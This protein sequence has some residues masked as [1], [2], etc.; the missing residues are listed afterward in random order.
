MLQ[1]FLPSSRRDFNSLSE[2]EIL[3]LAISSEED[4][5]A[6][7]C[8]SRRGASF[9]AWRSRGSPS[10]HPAAMTLGI[11]LAS[12]AFSPPAG[13]KLAQP[14]KGLA[15]LALPVLAAGVLAVGA[16]TAA[17]A[18]SFL[19]VSVDRAWAEEVRRREAEEELRR[20][21]EEA[22]DALRQRCADAMAAKIPRVQLAVIPDAGHAS[23]IDQPERFNEAVGSFLAGLELGA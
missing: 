21:E 13:S 4:D 20:S 16:P 19:A 7:I 8:S 15:E 3:A 14:P 1:R 12:F 17:F 2:Q 23:N 5:A 10:A 9:S 11:A 22:A 18:L 6:A